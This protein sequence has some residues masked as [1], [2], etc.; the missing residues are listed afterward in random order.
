[1]RRLEQWVRRGH[2]AKARRLQE[3]HNRACTLKLADA[4]SR[5]KGGVRLAAHDGVVHDAEPAI[6]RRRVLVKR[7]ERQLGRPER[8]GSEEG[9][10]HGG[11]PREVP[12]KMLDAS[13]KWKGMV[14]FRT[15]GWFPID[16]RYA[17]IQL[18]CNS[19]RGDPSDRAL[20]V[21]ACVQLRSLGRVERSPLSLLFAAGPPKGIGLPDCT[22]LL[23]VVWRL[24]VLLL[25]HD[26]A[27]VDVDGAYAAG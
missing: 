16:L 3:G 22:M 17:E 11:V 9:E 5:G 15:E 7:Q 10:D 23:I 25:D 20:A 27:A 24:L 18:H 2:L 8:D 14:L 1:M 13:P 19:P 6:A 4:R 12:E 21:G 26:D